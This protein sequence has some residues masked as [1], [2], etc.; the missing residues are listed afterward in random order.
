M[1]LGLRLQEARGARMEQRLSEGATGALC[2]QGLQT[3]TMAVGGE[4]LEERKLKRHRCKLELESVP[5]KLREEPNG[6]L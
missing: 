5:K 1:E 6:V 4:R 2:H 3:S